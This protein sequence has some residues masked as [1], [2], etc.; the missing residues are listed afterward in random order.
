MRFTSAPATT[1]S[2]SYSISGS[3]TK[4]YETLD[5][6]SIGLSQPAFEYACKGYFKLV[7]NHE[8]HDG[9]YL[10][11]CD[12]SQ[13]SHKKRL[14]VIDMTNQKVLINTYVA[15]GRNSGLDYATHFSNKP[16]SLQSSLGFYSTASTYQGNNG[17]SLRMRGLEPGFNNNAWQRA[18][19]VHGA[20]YIG[21]Q[22]LQNAYMGRSYGCP[23]VPRAESGKLI[24]LIKNGSCLFIYAKDKNY[25]KYSKILN[26]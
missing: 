16:E 26:A 12:L 11:I 13:S 22:R 2:S 1:R 6:A 23:A 4:L 8:V 21:P 3:F 17:L 20:D 14:Y 10:T 24:N 18:I 15:H 5:L 9:S 7:A 25:L 19:V